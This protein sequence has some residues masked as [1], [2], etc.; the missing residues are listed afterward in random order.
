MHW[1]TVRYNLLTVNGQQVFEVSAVAY[2][3]P[4]VVEIY[5][6]QFTTKSEARAAVAA[7]IAKYQD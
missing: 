3:G 1:L 7:F 4:A 6:A 2:D 5:N